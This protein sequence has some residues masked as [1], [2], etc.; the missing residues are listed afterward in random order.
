MSDPDVTAFAV[1][2]LLAVGGAG[3][4]DANQGLDHLAGIQ[5]TDGGVGGAG[6]TAAH[7]A[8]STG[9][10]GQAFL[11]GGRSAQ[12]R[13]AQGYLSALQYGCDHPAEL[14]GGIA[15]DG[16]AF[17]AAAAE[18]ATVQDQD[19]R[20]TSQAL[21]ALAGTPLYAV[22]GTGADATAPDLACAAPS[23]TTTTSP[24]S[25]TSS[26]T[27]SSTSSTTS[28]SGT[29]SSST[30]AGS[31]SSTAGSGGGLGVDTPVSATPASLAYTGADIGLF[32][33]AG[34]LLLLLGAGALVLARRKGVHA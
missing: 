3:D 20:A 21:L 16:A 17:T 33:V 9:L 30:A 23:S 29:S 19:R 2:A 1:Q 28:G 4:A 14:R 10:A 15:Y 6:P 26:T 18:G 5:G 13:A 27:S 7:N 12:A 22:S 34:V 32:V 25:T 31:G 24:T 11:A 8:N